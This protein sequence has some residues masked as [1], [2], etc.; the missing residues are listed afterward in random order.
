M[1]LS[2]IKEVVQKDGIW[3]TPVFPDGSK[4][5]F[6]FRIIGRNTE[7]YRRALHKNTVKLV[8]GRKGAAEETVGSSDMFMA[9]VLDW[10][11]ITDNGK[12]HSCTRENKEKM[13]KDASLRWLVEQVE[14]AILDDSLFLSVKE[15]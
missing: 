14:N 6:K 9:C 11:G 1:E 15:S 3:F 2:S 8:S 13:H 7:E 4:C 12:E 10:D 5:D